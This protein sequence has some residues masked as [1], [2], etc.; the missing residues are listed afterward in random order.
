MSNRFS[1]LKDKALV[2]FITS[3]YPSQTACAEYMAAFVRGGADVIELGIPFSDPLADGPVIQSTSF[4][5]LQNG[6]TI[7]STLE[8][9]RKFRETPIVLMSYLNPMLAYGLD[10]FFKDATSAGV[11]GVIPVDLIPEEA[12]EF[13]SNAGTMPVTFLVSPTCKPDRLKLI[14]SKTTGFVYLVSLKGVTGARQGLPEGLPEFIRR[15]RKVCKQPLYVGFGISTP[16]QVQQVWK[17]A[18]GVVIGSAILKQ[19]EAG[20]SPEVIDHYIASLRGERVRV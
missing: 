8:L 14:A 15:V 11:S 3:G 10:R 18:D 1:S 17:H 6:A 12:D 13:L 20:A 4:K 5:A 16:E 19:I 7:E 2:P 9:A